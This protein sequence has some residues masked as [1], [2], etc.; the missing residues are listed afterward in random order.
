M[1]KIKNVTTDE[2]VYL[3]ARHTFGRNHF[4]VNTPAPG[5]DVSQSH[6]KIIWKSDGWYLHDLS[7]N[8]TLINS[9]F[10]N[11]Q[12]VKLLTGNKIYFGEHEDAAWEVLDL[13]PPSSFLTPV[14]QET[15]LIELDS[16]LALPSEEQPEVLLYPENQGWK[17]DKN[18][19]IL[20]LIHN[21]IYNIQNINYKY[22]SN[23]I[24]DETIDNGVLTK[25]AFFQ[26][27]LSA[28]EEHIR[29]K[30]ITQGHELDL[31]ER[32]HNYLLLALARKKLDDVEAGCVSDDQ[33]WIAIDDL[34]AD[35][36]KEFRK[37]V[38]V[39][40]L[41]LQIHRLRKLLMDTKP[42]GYLFCNVIQR[43]IGEIR[44]AHPYFQ[45]MKED[46]CVGELLDDPMQ[47]VSA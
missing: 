9:N 21:Q 34:L 46:E 2:V 42:Y 43:R 17:L 25:N 33:G 26:F 1:G 11:H 6:A 44:L 47:K 4:I 23:E 31:G 16:C 30:I 28:D 35:L 29:I 19:D 20:D 45:I 27:S 37:P 10:I 14:N 18:G 12:V 5:A 3:Y 40:N 38:D 24:F 7:R 13:S 39:F 36:S 32:V 41:N 8:G 22:V 15:Q